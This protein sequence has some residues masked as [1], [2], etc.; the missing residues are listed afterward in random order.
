MS[1]QGPKNM[2]SQGPQNMSSQGPKNMS[3]RGPKNMSSQSPKKCVFPDV[4]QCFLTPELWVSARGRVREE[5]FNRGA[6]LAFP[7]RTIR[8]MHRTILNHTKPNHTMPDDFYGF[9]SNCVCFTDHFDFWDRRSL[10]FT[11]NSF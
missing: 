10:C 8:T 7:H 1:S 5:N 3:S 4:K 9:G 2:S 11:S 6:P